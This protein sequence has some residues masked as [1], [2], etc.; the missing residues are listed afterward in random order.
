MTDF[1]FD[2]ALWKTWSAAIDWFIISLGVISGV[3]ALNNYSYYSA[4]DTRKTAVI[5]VAVLVLMLGFFPIEWGF[6][7]DRANYAHGFLEIQ[8]GRSNF[9]TWHNDIGFYILSLALGKF[10]SVQQYFVAVA[11][12]YIFN[13]Y[14]TIRKLVQS[15]AYW[16]LIAV[17][18]SLGF[19]SYTLNTMRAGLALS[20]I[21]LSFSFYP[22][23]W[24]MTVCLL[25]ASSIH[26]SATIPSLMIIVS[27]LYPNTKLYYKLW[28]LSIPVSF[29]AGSS[30]MSFFADVGADDRVSYLRTDKFTTYN[31]GF[32]I[33]FILYSLAPML[34]GGYYLFKRNFNDKFYR[35]IYDSF[36]L[37]NIFWILVIRAN[38]SD[39]FAYLSWFMIP[40]ILVYPLLKADVVGNQH[41]WLGLILLGETAF[42]FLL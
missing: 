13:Y 11:A 2:I 6:G 17:L 1:S 40:F 37:T 19:T 39:R 28:I 34:I 5:V 33:D 36:L 3:V 10:L 4:S 20:F 41:T 7:T 16:L 26:N 21:V 22:S 31:V 42:S 24:R 18:L 27:Y 15:K 8:S 35:L 29:V 30:F 23:K 14:Y 25:V 9:D 38:Y 32:R 12:I